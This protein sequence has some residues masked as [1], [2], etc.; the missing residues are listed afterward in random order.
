MEVKQTMDDYKEELEASFRKIYVGDLIA[1]TVIAVDEEEVILDLRYYAPG[2]I[3]A[4]DMSNDPG[5][6]ILEEI[7]VGDVIEATVI[8]TD[9]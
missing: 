2:V 6:Q 1:G 9:T 5:F 8:R 4:E 3:K 7:K